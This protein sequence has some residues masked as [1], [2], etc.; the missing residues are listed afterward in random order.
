[1][2]VG[3]VLNPSRRHAHVRL[4]DRGRPEVEPN[5]ATIAMDDGTPAFFAYHSEYLYPKRRMKLDVKPG[6]HRAQRCL[7]SPVVIHPLGERRGKES[8][9]AVTGP[10]SRRALQRS[11][12][13]TIRPPT[14]RVTR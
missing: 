6:E 7:F 13:M 12:L 3:G 5:G 2:V 1:M 14:S 10:R 4:D 9:A 11:Q 8:R